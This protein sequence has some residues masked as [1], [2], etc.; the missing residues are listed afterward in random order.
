[1]NKFDGL[2]GLGGY[3]FIDP[4]FH[5]KP[6]AAK[7]PET[8]KTFYV[9]RWSPGRYVTG[10]CPYHGKSNGY[11]TFTDDGV[12]KAQRFP[13]LLDAAVRLSKHD[14]KTYGTIVKVTEV[15]GKSEVRL[16]SKTKID[17][18]KPVVLATGA[19][20][21]EVANARG[22]FGLRYELRDATVFS[23]L[24]DALV[25]IQKEGKSNDLGVIEPLLAY[26]VET[27]TTP[28]TFTEVEVG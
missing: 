19:R 12:A 20:Y 8:S 6:V 21:I 25:A 27:I 11:F 3:T 14:R 22:Q 2:Y 23:D 10:D 4:I 28:S 1:M 7:V 15:P 16:V 26:Q 5:P 18:T 17:A 13:T 24:G 9:I